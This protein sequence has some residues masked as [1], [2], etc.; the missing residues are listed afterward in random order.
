MVMRNITT[1]FS[2][3]RYVFLSDLTDLEVDFIHL[4]CVNDLMKYT[5]SSKYL[6]Y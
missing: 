1:H 4:A 6:K 5:K 3:L 2:F